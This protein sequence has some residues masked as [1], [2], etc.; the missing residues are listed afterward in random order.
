MNYTKLKQQPKQGGVP[1][2][3]LNQAATSVTPT[4]DSIV[5]APTSLATTS[6][7][8]IPTNASVAF[9][10]GTQIFII[11]N[12]AGV[13]TISGDTGVTLN[14]RSTSRQPNGRYAEVKLTKTATDTWY[15]TGDLAL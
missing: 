13:L 9:P 10:I 5:T 6:A 7:I 14:T 1:R 3:N 8:T 2:V 11:Q 12:G 15:L 4:R